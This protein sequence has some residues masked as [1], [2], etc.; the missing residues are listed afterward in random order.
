MGGADSDAPS[1]AGAAQRPTSRLQ[2]SGTADGPAVRPEGADVLLI[3]TDRTVRG[4][5][6]D[7]RDGTTSRLGLVTFAEFSR[8][9]ARDGA[10]SRRPLPGADVT[11]TTMS[12]PGD[13]HRLGTAVTLYLDDWATADRGTFVYVDALSPFLDANGLEATFQFLHLLVQ[14]V[15]ELD[16]TLTVR[17]DPSAVGETAVDTLGAL[18][19]DVVATESTAVELDRDDLHEL[20]G[21]ARR[22]FVLRA[23]L[24]ESPATLER[25]A[26]GLARRELGTEE[27]GS[28]ARSRARTALASVHVPRLV[29]ADVVSFDRSSGEV[30]LAATAGDADR[31]ETLLEEAFDGE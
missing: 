22:R 4:V 28:G 14:T 2:L 6:S 18:F 13:L 26:A 8:S 17:L 9:A 19:D 15:G 20:L 30:T 3:S 7:W 23:L 16:A 24:E 31:I 21:N 12:D 10:P 11:V 29:E 27:P 25:L 1:G 5:L